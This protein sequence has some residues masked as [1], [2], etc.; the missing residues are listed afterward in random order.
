MTIAFLF[1]TLSIIFMI[2]GVKATSIGLTML[3]FLISGV[4]L[5]LYVQRRIK[6]EKEEN[7]E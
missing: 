3:L 2:Q 6:L 7:D 4:F 5:E 1:S